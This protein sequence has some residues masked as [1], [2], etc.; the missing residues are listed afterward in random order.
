MNRDEQTYAI[1]GS[2]MTVHRELGHG[3]W[4]RCTRMHW[5]IELAEQ[6]IPFARE[7]ELSAAYKGKILSTTYRADFV[8][9]EEVVVELKALDRLTAKE[10]SQLIN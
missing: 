9:Y 6:Y 10:E 3:F 5:L 7:V 2:A 1:I 8:F 4:R